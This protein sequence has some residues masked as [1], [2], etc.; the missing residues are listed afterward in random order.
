VIR[1]SVFNSV[2]GALKALISFAAIPLLIA[3]LGESDYGLWTLVS[4]V[5]GLVA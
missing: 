2:G 1:S 5:V 3:A 4:A